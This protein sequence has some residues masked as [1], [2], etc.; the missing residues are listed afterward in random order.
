MIIKLKRTNMLLSVFPRLQT[1]LQAFTTNQC[2][3][4]L[5]MLTK[6][7]T[8]Y[9]ILFVSIHTIFSWPDLNVVLLTLRRISWFIYIFLSNTLLQLTNTIFTV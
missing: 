7:K 6:Q 5:G 9:F 4:G 3:R 1:H 2:C 8:A